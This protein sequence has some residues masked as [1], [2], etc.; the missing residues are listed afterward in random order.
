MGAERGKTEAVVLNRVIS[1]D[2]QEPYFAKNGGCKILTIMRDAISFKNVYLGQYFTENRQ[3][4][5]LEIV[6]I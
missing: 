3:I 6:R 4:A 1:N 5:S 2:L